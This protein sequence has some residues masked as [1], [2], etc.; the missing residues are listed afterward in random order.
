MCGAVPV[1]EVRVIVNGEVMDTFTDVT[2]PGDPTSS[3]FV[4]LL[5]IE[6]DIPVGSLLPVVG[7]AW[8][9]V[10]AG[11]A[12]P[13]SGDLDCD[14]IPDTGDTNADGTVDWRDVEDLEEEPEEACF[15]DTGPVAS[16][17]A[18]DRDTPLWFYQTTVPKGYPAAFTNPFVLDLDGGGFEGVVR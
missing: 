13:L 6:L 4:D 8:I 3:S 17:A 14:G 15:D 11:V 12:L 16:L 9:S 2:I 7:D 5:R 1:S 18:P 10:E